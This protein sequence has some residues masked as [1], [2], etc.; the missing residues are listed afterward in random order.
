MLMLIG[1]TLPLGDAVL[2]MGL[3]AMQTAFALPIV[4]MF[5]MGCYGVIVGIAD[6]IKWHRAKTTPA[7]RLTEEGITD[8][9]GSITGGSVYWDE[10]LSVSK[11]RVADH[12]SLAVQLTDNSAYLARIP[13]WKRLFLSPNIAAYGTAFL[14]SE[15]E[16]AVPLD[17][18][19][20]A[21]ENAQQ[22]F[23]EVPVTEAP[24]Q[25]SA[26]WWTAIPPEERIVVSLR[27]E[28]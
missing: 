11:V 8:A 27:S 5:V 16:L 17:Q 20:L 21:I 3:G 22:C 15:S 1:A 2:L 12:Y 6:I 4:F 24:P 10:I 9:T 28:R 26:H 25:P 19:I 18:A 14:V 23:K 13:A 7:L